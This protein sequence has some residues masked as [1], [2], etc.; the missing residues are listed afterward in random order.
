M[1]VRNNYEMTRIGI[2]RTNSQTDEIRT[3]VKRKLTGNDFGIKPT[4][5]SVEEQTDMLIRLATGQYKLAQM[6]SVWFAFW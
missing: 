2:P 4:P 1:L 5:L 6:F 3:T